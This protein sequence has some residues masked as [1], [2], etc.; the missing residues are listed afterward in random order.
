MRASMWRTYYTSKTLAAKES[1][2]CS[3]CFPTSTVQ[4]DTQKGTQVISRVGEKRALYRGN[5]MNKGPELC[6][7]N[8]IE[9]N[10]AGHRGCA[11]E[12]GFYPR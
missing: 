1:G 6:A 8:T 2:K 10:W 5:T 9:A 4:E 3:L 12:L 11:K 7:G